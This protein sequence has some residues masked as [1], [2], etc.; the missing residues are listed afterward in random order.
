MERFPTNMRVSRKAKSLSQE[1]LARL[2]DISMSN[3]SKYERGVCAPSAENLSRIAA[4]VDRTMDELWFGDLKQ[5]EIPSRGE[6]FISGVPESQ[7]ESLLV[8]SPS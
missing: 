8:G 5:L 6:T 1:G 4:M 3:I 2:A 7:Q